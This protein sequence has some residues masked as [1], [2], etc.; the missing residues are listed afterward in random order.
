[1]SPE[2][3]I[4]ALVRDLERFCEVDLLPKVRLFIPWQVP[5]K[6]IS[7]FLEERILSNA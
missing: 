5:F 4:E 6:P 7:G 1:M 2:D 3:S